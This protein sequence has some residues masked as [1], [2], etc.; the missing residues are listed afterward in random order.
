MPVAVPDYPR[1]VDHVTE[2]IVFPE[3]ALDV[4]E[5]FTVDDVTVLEF[6]LGVEIAMDGKDGSLT[7]I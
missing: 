4:P 7:V 3:P 2:L 1:S 5:K 6:R